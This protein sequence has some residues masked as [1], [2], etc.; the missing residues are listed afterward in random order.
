MARAVLR[1]A[2]TVLLTF[3]ILCAV[4]VMGF[5]F[6][7]RLINHQL[8]IVRSGSMEPAIRTGSVV[9]V[10]PVPPQTL[11]VG[12]VITYERPDSQ[13]MIVTHRVVEVLDPTASAAL[14]GSPAVPVGGA[15]PAFRTKGDANGVADSYAVQYRDTGW[16][17]VASVPY[18]GY[19]YNALS[20]PSARALLVGVP[21]V[22]LSVSFL[23]DLWRRPS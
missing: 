11:T 7:P 16:K 9:L 12:D 17:V 20:H 5:S 10:R 19:F 4:A 23:R 8:L 13:D 15:G 6:A 18:A 1:T 3:W 14:P 22:L 21:A 2:G